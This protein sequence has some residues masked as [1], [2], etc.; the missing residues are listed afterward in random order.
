[1]VTRTVGSNGPKKYA[2]SGRR[3]PSERL[4][5]AVVESIAR[6]IRMSPKSLGLRASETKFLQNLSL[7]KLAVESNR[8]NQ[9]H[10]KSVG[11]EVSETKFLRMLSLW[12]LALANPL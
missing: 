6:M 11:L 3:R 7:L 4:A 8:M 10:L 12:K 2:A 9:R 5:I 1:M